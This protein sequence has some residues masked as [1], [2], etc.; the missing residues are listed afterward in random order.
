MPM[1]SSSSSA[2]MPALPP[3]FRFHPTDEEL[4][5][6]YL[7]R[8]AA[9]MPSPVPIIAEVNIYKCNPW[10]LPG[11]ALFGENEWYFFSPRDRK[12]P[13]GA[14]PNRAAGSGYW[15]A[16]G[17][18]KA[19]LST[20]ANESI[21]VK[22]ALVFYRGKPPKGVKTDWI[23]HEYRLT[24]ADNRATK[25]RGSSMRLDDWVLCRIHKKCGNLPN[26]SSSDQEQEHE[27]ESS[28]VE[29][30][31]NNHTVSS[32]KSEAFDGDGDGDDQLQ[33]QQFR[34]MAIA[35]SCSLTD[36]LN[37]VDYAALSHLLLDGSAGAGASSSDAGLDYQL[38]PENPLIY[39]QP[40]W[41]QTLHYNNNNNN[42]YV[43]HDTI[44]VPQLTE[45]RLDDYGMKR[46][47]SSGSL[48]CSQL[49]VPA[50]QYSGMLIHPFLSQQLHM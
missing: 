26:F 13:N 36:L 14:R 16:T 7:G 1:G 21:G 6:H 41:Q 50:D 37:T 5:V 22:K 19:I 48:Y 43:N 24:A 12:Y 11:K 47:R 20:P 46:K 25:R 9:S 29:D 28:T 23:M 10:D 39:S 4:I 38:P 49:Q 2:A 17:T 40:P 8:Q 30:S 34:P 15:K 31:H 18:D 27:Q 35:K 3:G 32:P 45:A 33:L 44:D 42:G